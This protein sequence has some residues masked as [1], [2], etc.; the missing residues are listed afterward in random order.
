[1]ATAVT[2][3]MNEQHFAG[4]DLNGKT[5]VALF[6]LTTMSATGANN[7]SPAAALG[8]YVINDQA[9]DVATYSI[10]LG[11]P[12][13]GNPTIAKIIANTANGPVT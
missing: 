5:G 9:L 3:D 2:T 7:S 13:G 11:A 4:V 6:A 1:M 12:S 10:T 8:A